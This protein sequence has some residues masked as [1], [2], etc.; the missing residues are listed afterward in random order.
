MLDAALALEHERES[1]E[2]E[3]VKTSVTKTL[4]G[5]LAHLLENG[6]ALSFEEPCLFEHQSGVTLSGVIDLVARH[7]EATLAID[8]KSS[9][10]AC[11]ELSARAQIIA[12]ASALEEIMPSSDHQIQFALWEI[13]A[14]RP[15][16]PRSL[17]EMERAF[18]EEALENVKEL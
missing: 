13:G 18:L 8:F 12:Y 14:E 11:E 4:C 2:F 3:A 7:D 16:P 15:V 9:K 10:Q 6:F 5:P 1:P 17:G